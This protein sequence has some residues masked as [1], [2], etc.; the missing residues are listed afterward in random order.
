[1]NDYE[2]LLKTAARTWT[3]EFAIGKRSVP[4]G[5]WV[6]TRSG[7]A[8]GSPPTNIIHRIRVALERLLELGEPS[9]NA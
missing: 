9:N 5:H 4:V 6:P 8:F 2:L 3:P 7:C 1:M